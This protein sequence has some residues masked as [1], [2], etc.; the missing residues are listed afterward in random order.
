MMKKLM[1]I[2]IM[3]IIFQTVQADNDFY[4]EDDVFEQQKIILDVHKN[5]KQAEK[6]YQ[7]YYGKQYQLEGN[8]QLEKEYNRLEGVRYQAKLF[9]ASAYRFNHFKN[10]IEQISAQSVTP[11]NMTYQE[12]KRWQQ[13]QKGTLKLI[14]MMPVSVQES[15]QQYAI[16]L[17]LLDRMAQAIKGER[18]QR[19]QREKFRVYLAKQKKELN[20]YKRQLKQWSAEIR[21]QI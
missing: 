15:N 16:I 11:V 10:Q 5:W 6:E 1:S 13:W 12:L 7:D 4:I 17:L 21:G 3:F 18:L 9:V 14:N 20:V 2:L 8:T 19:H